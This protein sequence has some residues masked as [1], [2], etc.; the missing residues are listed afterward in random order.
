[1]RTRRVHI[2]LRACV[3][4]TPACVTYPVTI[5]RSSRCCKAINFGISFGCCVA[6]RVVHCAVSRRRL[7]QTKRASITRTRIGTRISTPLPRDG[8]YVASYPARGDQPVPIERQGRKTTLHQYTST[9]VGHSI[10]RETK[11]QAQRLPQS[12]RHVGSRWAAQRVPQS[13]RH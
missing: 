1:M 9:Q 7:V 5:S 8:L 10:E 11:R 2:A 4:N 13:G 6:H 3:H 12:G